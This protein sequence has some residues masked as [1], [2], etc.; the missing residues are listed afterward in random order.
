MASID[1]YTSIDDMSL[2]L[3]KARLGHAA[4]AF[5]QVP[6]HLQLGVVRVRVGPPR[7]GGEGGR[8][9]ALYRCVGDGSSEVMYVCVCMHGTE[10][11]AYRRS[12]GGLADAKK[13]MHGD[14]ALAQEAQHV[15]VQDAPAHLGLDQACCS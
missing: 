13:G 8:G 4:D 10:R 11:W 1:M 7:R 14:V 6:H 12:G 15:L 9:P 3:G 5:L 2:T